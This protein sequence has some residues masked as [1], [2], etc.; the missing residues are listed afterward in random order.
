MR[1][2]EV[3]ELVSDLGGGKTT[4]VR[5][6]AQG[7]GSRDHVSSPSFTLSNQYQNG[8]L[9]LYHFDF[10]RLQEPGVMRDELAEVLANSQAVVVVEWGGI[11]EDVLPADKLTIQITADGET[12]R[13]F[14]FSYP[15]HLAY[16]LSDA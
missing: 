4:F 2:G 12:S 14:N 15:E 5:G 11:V 10:Y 8:D 9:T 3:V 16:L 1:G 7:M 6:L 13:S